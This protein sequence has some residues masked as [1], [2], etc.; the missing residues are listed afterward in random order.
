MGQMY[1]HKFAYRD[2][3]AKAEFDEAWKQAFKAFARSGNWGGVETGVTHHQT[4]G[5][6]W[7]GYC[8]IEVDD[9]EAFAR[10]QLFCNTTYGF[11]A[12]TT[13]EALFDM[14]GAFEEVIDAER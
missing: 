14:D 1:M 2:G 7:G 5:T 12:D 10:Y 6:G 11:A 4:Y 9:P 8:L 3:V 13:F